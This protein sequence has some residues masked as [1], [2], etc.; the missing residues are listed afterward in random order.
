MAAGHRKKVYGKH[1]DAVFLYDRNIRGEDADR[2]G[3]QRLIADQG[4]V[5]RN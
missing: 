2:F 1:D 3:S 4:L 5:N